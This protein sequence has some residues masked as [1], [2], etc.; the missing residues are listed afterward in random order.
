MKLKFVK[1]ATDVYI[2]NLRL[3]AHSREALEDALRYVFLKYASYCKLKSTTSW[4][5]A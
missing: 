1:I 4:T 3:L 2:D 5:S